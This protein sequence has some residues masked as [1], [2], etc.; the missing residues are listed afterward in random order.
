MK[1]DNFNTRYFFFLLFLS[2]VGVL[3]VFWPFMSAIMVAAVL[4]V[5]FYAM[6]RKLLLSL[7]G[8][9][10]LAAS[11]MCVLVGLLIVLP[12]VVVSSLVVVEVKNA[13]DQFIS[14]P[15]ALKN[16]LKNVNIF[17]SHFNIPILSET[18]FLNP[19]SASSDIQSISKTILSVAQKT[20]AQISNFVLWLFVMFFSFFYFLIDG[21][22]IL[23]KIIKLSPMR[24]EQ[25]M[26]LAEHFDSISRATLKGTII[27][28]FIQGLLGG[29]IF[30][31]TGIPSP[32]T[33][34]VVMFILSVI[35]MV[36]AGLVWFPASIF[37]LMNGDTWQGITVLLFGV[38]VISTVDNLLRPR[39]VGRDAEMHPLLVFFSTVG[40][41][42]KFG[43]FGFVIGPVVTALFLALIKIYEQE[44]SRQLTQYNHHDALRTKSTSGVVSKTSDKS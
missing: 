30:A 42:L 14:Q 28:G 3:I 12:I 23:A 6:Y 22:K 10:T 4:A 32:V 37:L 21:K 1:I 8:R 26:M 38:F 25:E 40:G 41:I 19:N 7:K 24:D 11:L 33:W 9:E 16:V 2:G 15:D 18:D 5:V 29:I 43:F 44:F 34:G 39:L 31:I 35:P 27:L 20:Y 36:G 17:L 13:Y